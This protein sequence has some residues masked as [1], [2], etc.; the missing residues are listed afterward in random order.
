VSRILQLVD[1]KNNQPTGGPIFEASLGQLVL[2]TIEIIIRD[3]SNSLIIV[4][5]FPGA[6]DPLDDS[7]YNIASSTSGLPYLWWFYYYGA[8]S[9]KEFL[10]DK[11][12]FTGFNLYPGTYTVTYY[13]LVSTSGLFVL[14]PTMA[15]DVFQPEL[16]GTSAGGTFSTPAYLSLPI[17]DMGICLPWIDRNTPIDQ[18]SPYL[19]GTP[20]AITGGSLS[21]GLSVGLGVGLGIGIPVLVASVGVASFLIYNKYVFFGKP[22]TIPAPL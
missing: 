5:A 1:T 3:Y 19:G 6:L 10:Q 15:Y 18:L 12:V 21:N 20:S 22:E 14:P 2:T 4:D 16:M 9:Q 8:F 11:V 7:I 13:S 17:V